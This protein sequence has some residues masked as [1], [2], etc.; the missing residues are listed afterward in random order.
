MTSFDDLLREIGPL[1]NQGFAW[2][3]WTIHPDH[4][5]ANTGYADRLSELNEAQALVVCLALAELIVAGIGHHDPEHWV[6]D[7]V[8][9]GWA[10]FSASQ[11]PRYFE[12]DDNDW[13]GPQREMLA[14]ALIVLNDALFCR[15]ERSKIA[16][17][18]DWLLFY[19][20]KLYGSLPRFD[21]WLVR[22]LVRLEKRGKGPGDSP[23]DFTDLPL[24]PCFSRQVLDLDRPDN[25]QNNDDA[26]LESDLARWKRTG[27]LFLA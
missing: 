24:E 19:T 13:K 25:Q 4:D 17:R 15:D 7:Y 18:A 23:E 6:R 26:L 22:L 10:G 9:A 20:Q 5:L 21:D 2:D 27:N 16:Y 1:A 8:Q 3:Q 11:S 12:T 14:M